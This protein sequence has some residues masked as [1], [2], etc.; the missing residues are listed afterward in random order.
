MKD[1]IKLSD[2]ISA[3]VYETHSGLGVT[4]SIDV[5]LG[6]A[7]NQHCIFGNSVS[8]IEPKAAIELAD[9]LRACAMSALGKLHASDAQR[10]RD[11]ALELAMAADEGAVA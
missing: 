11:V 2:G 8:G 1:R 10:V 5:I 3:T 7:G 9:Q 6:R 4:M